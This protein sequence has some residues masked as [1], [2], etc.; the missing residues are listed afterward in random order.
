MCRGP[1][2]KYWQLS[3]NYS[4]ENF[5]TFCQSLCRAPQRS[6]IWGLKSATVNE[7]WHQQEVR[8][9]KLLNQGELGKL[10]RAL[11]LVLR[12]FTILSQLEVSGGVWREG[13]KRK[14]VKE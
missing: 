11:Q 14:L 1:F 2:I 5:L 12:D 13:V 4:L 10:I 9:T 3:R 8:T 7:C 6:V